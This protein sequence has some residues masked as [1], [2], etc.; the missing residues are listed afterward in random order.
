[1]GQAGA[2][3]CTVLCTVQGTVQ[4]TVWGTVHGHCSLK[5]FLCMIYCI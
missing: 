1:M 2:V 4:V 5:I 3:Q